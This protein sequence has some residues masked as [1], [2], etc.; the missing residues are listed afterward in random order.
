MIKTINAESHPRE[1]QELRNLT[2]DD[3]R[4]IL[5]DCQYTREEMSQ[6][7]GLCDCYVSL[8]RSEGF[9]RGPAEAMLQGKPVIATKYSGNTDFMNADTSFLVDYR[10]VP[11]AEGEYPGARGQV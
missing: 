5:R 6:L 2:G 11:V 8:H 1:W 3:R 4:I 7:I 9:G 10:L